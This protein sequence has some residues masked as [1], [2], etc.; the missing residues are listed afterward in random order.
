MQNRIVENKIYIRNILFI[1]K[2]YSVKIYL[3]DGVL[4]PRRKYGHLRTKLASKV[5]KDKCPLC[6]AGKKCPQHP[7]G[8]VENK[9]EK[10]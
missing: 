4:M 1:R 3:V 8:F 6:R 2:V 7:E 5:Q 10:K 9:S